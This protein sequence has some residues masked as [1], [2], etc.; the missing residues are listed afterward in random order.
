MLTPS[1]QKRENLDFRHSDPSKDFLC[2]VY[3]G[4]FS[5]AVQASVCGPKTQY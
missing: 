1:H 3:A 2:P 4:V 5:T